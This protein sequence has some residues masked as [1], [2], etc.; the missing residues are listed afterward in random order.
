M[1]SKGGTHTP[2]EEDASR[3]GQWFN[4]EQRD[5]EWQ[6]PPVIAGN[7]DND[8]DVSV[9]ENQAT[10]KKTHLCRLHGSWKIGAMKTQI[11]T[12]E[13]TDKEDG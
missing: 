13:E 6:E 5:R 9:V 3:R 11:D 4:V 12:Q 1:H 7:A 10:M 8:D 2:K